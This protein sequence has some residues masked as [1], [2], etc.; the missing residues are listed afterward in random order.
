M[1]S[2]DLRVCSCFQDG[3]SRVTVYERNAQ[4]CLSGVSDRLLIVSIIGSFQ[5]GKS[6][7]ISHLTGDSTIGIGHGV[8]VQTKGV[9]LYGPYSLNVLKQRWNVPEVPDDQTKVIFV[10]TEGFQGHDVGKSLEENKLLMCQLIS[11][12]I[13]I[14]QVCI[15][16][17]RAN[18]TIGSVEVFRYLLDVVQRISAGANATAAGSMTLIDISTN[19]G[20]FETGVVDEEGRAVTAAYHPADDPELFE[21]ACRFLAK[22]QSGRLLKAAPGI[23]RSVQVSINHFW[24]LP[25]FTGGVPIG[26]QDRNFATGFALVV[27]HLFSVLD[28]IK[29][30]NVISGRGAFTSLKYVLERLER[31]NIEELVKA[32]RQLAR[33]TTVEQK[34]IPLIELAVS[35]YRNEIKQVFEQLE[36]KTLEVPESP[37]E[38]EMSY[39]QQSTRILEEIRSQFSTDACSQSVVQKNLEQ[40]ERDM[41]DIGRKTRNQFLTQLLGRQKRWA[42][43]R[44]IL[45][46]DRKCSLTKSKILQ[47]TARSYKKMEIE[48]KLEELRQVCRQELLEVQS[49]LKLSDEVRESFWDMFAPK[50]KD[51]TTEL[52]QFA[53][54]TVSLNVEIRKAQIR[55]FIQEFA[56]GLSNP[57]ATI[58]ALL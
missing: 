7:F 15:L 9:W 45:A 20:R 21:V 50:I 44:M 17:Q 31:E 57:G 5:L 24:P 22:V 35:E 25:A 28:E 52:I 12:Y 10:D 23:A 58:A 19:L 56:E 3:E 33:D 37:S 43:E 36:V 40:A 55:N 48:Q 8:N 54:D 1:Q 42:I 29:G 11:P 53:R 4:L 34:L 18:V 38:I 39:K 32:A 30:A 27:R 6:S 47:N 41:V 16:M 51:V 26:D 49:L 46:L 2:C 14:S 13:A